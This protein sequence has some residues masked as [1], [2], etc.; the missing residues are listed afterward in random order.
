MLRR[1]HLYFIA[2]FTI[3]SVMF[4]SIAAFAVDEIMIESAFIINFT[5]FIEWP[6]STTPAG[7]RKIDICVIGDSKIINAEQVFKQASFD[8]LDISLVKEKNISSISTHCQMLFISTSE[9]E[10]IADIILSIKDKPIL[11]IG[12]TDEFIERGVMINFVIDD[13]KVKFVINKGAIVAAGLKVDAQLL[14]IAL[15]VIDK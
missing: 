4:S 3:V 13:G 7:Q 6:D 8:K 12:D 5:K 2:F 9:S 14:E 1:F 11:T 15:K 10:K